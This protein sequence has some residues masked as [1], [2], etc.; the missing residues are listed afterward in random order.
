[1]KTFYILF[2]LL[3]LTSCAGME[4][5]KM[6]KT[7][8]QSQIRAQKILKKNIKAEILTEDGIRH[9]IIV[10]EV[11]SN[12]VKGHNIENKNQTIKIDNIF[13]VK[14]KGFDG[15][16]TAQFASTSYLLYVAIGGL[17]WLASYE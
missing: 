7:T 5:V 4:R 8:L 15:L 9:Q 17:L 14:T 13:S 1:M 12:E 2:S 6:D 3:L 16:K 10:S 11:T